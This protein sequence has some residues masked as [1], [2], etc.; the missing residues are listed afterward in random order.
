VIAG[1][2][3]S[4]LHRRRQVSLLVDIGTNGEFIMGNDQW[5]VACAGAAG[6]AFEGG[7]VAAGM[8]AKNGAVDEVEIDSQRRVHYHAIGEGKAEGICGSG[9]VDALSEMLLAGI[10]DRAGQFTG[11]VKQQVI[12]PTDASATGRE[13]LITQTDID[14]IMLTKA[15]VNAAVGTLVES[16]GLGMD[17]IDTFYAAGAFGKF[18]DVESAVTI[19][20]Y[21]D[22]PRERMILLGNSS[23]EGARQVL[24]NEGKL[25]EAENIVSGITN[26]EL[27]SSPTFMSKFTSSSFFPHT[28][29]EYYP[30]VAAKLAA[31]GLLR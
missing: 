16:V 9:L 21:P 30:T 20:L 18:I 2:L 26:F 29:L 28:N 11:A 3:D 13:I 7:V 24:L 19:G 27:N 14:S 31:R 6:P 4:N 5:L 22:L 23:L 1:T 25:R 17:Q 10:I 12:V 15:A 8:R